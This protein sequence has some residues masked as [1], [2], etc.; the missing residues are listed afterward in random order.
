[1]VQTCALPIYLTDIS[2]DF[3]AI[4]YSDTTMQADVQRLTFKEKSGLYLQDFSA[5]S[6]V[7]NTKM[8]FTDLVLHTNRSRVGDYLAFY[9]DSFADFSDF[10]KKVDIEGTLQDAFVDS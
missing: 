3:K 8:E 9:Y 1:G 10:V 7:S 5:Q 4:R 6:Y 2:G